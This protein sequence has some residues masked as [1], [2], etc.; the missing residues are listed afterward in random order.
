M[1]SGRTTGELGVRVKPLTAANLFDSRYQ[2]RNKGYLLLTLAIRKKQ[3]HNERVTTNTGVH[4]RPSCQFRAASRFFRS[5]F[6]PP[7]LM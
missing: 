1:H 7:C 4:M 6:T 5:A 3:A 2:P